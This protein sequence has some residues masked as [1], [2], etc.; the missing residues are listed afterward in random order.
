MSEPKEK[1]LDRC[2]RFIKEKPWYVWL[3]VPAFISS[4]LISMGQS[5]WSDGSVFRCWCNLV[6]VAMLVLLFPLFI[7]LMGISQILRF[8]GVP[9]YMLNS[10]NS[11]VLA[12]AMYI[13]TY[14]F[15][16]LATCVHVVW[17]EKNITPRRKQ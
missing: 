6:W 10:E 16:V 11:I 3:S 13:C 17:R 9:D 1:I 5:K 8:S 4:F 12:I 15:G 2:L 14:I 7:I